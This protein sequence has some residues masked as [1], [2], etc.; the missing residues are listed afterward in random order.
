MQVQLLVSVSVFL[1][2]N[3]YNV[4]DRNLFTFHQHYH[5]FN[6]NPLFLVVCL[7]KYKAIANPSML[8]SLSYFKCC[9]SEKQVPNWDRGFSS[10]KAPA[11]FVPL[12]CILQCISFLKAVRRTGYWQGRKQCCLSGQ[13]CA[14]GC[15]CCPVFPP[16][17]ING[18]LIYIILTL[19]QVKFLEFLCKRMKE[20]EKKAGGEKRITSCDQSLLMLS[21]DK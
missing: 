15:Y 12:F 13:N 17:L 21:C 14:T 7:S 6:M 3:M 19:N 1:K 18:V 11:R 2:I 10:F 5:F 20:L 16:S 4:Q 9:T 8:Q